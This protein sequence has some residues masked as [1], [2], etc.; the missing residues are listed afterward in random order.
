MDHLRARV[1]A[2]PIWSECSWV[3]RIAS[4][5]STRIPSRANRRSISFAEKPQSSST[6]VVV[7]PLPAS[8]P[9]AL[10][11]LP[12]P[13]L[14]NRIGETLV[15]LRVQQR[16]DPLGVRRVIELT[17]CIDDSHLGKRIRL[18]AHID[19]ELA[20]GLWRAATEQRSE[21]P[22]WWQLRHR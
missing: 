3:I 11:S 16:N 22:G 2:L 4:S 14:A 5:S 9:N 12:L 17:I 19:Q 6:R 15:Q 1:N 20:R 7:V 10:P 13:R 21:Q 18:R 8:T